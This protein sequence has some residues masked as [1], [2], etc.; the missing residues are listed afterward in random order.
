M[1]TVLGKSPE[2]AGYL[3]MVSK[4]YDVFADILVGTMSDRTRSRYAGCCA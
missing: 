3:L 2:I 4:L 1:T